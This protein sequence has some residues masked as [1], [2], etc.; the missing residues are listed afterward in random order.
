[1]FTGARLALVAFLALRPG[2][3]PVED[4]RLPAD[5]GTDL[6][7]C[8]APEH[9]QF[10]FWAGDWDVSDVSN[11]DSIKARARVER[12]LDGCALHELYEGS[13]GLTGESFSIYDASRRV[14]H[15]SWVTNRGQL[16]MIEGGMDGNRMILTG[17]DYTGGGAGVLLRGVWVPIADG[18]RETAETSSDHGR[19]WLPLF[20]LLFRKHAS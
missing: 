9:R 14:W 11:P 12:I 15:Q 5:P 3:S 18:V 7:A 19:T 10:D 13:S 20:D 16:L 6:A 8:A 1:V 2:G 4:R 17:T